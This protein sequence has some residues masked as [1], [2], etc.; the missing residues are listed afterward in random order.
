MFRIGP[1][2]LDVRRRQLLFAANDVHLTPKAFDLLALLADAAPRVVTKTELHRNLWPHRIVSDA[3]LVGLVK[4]LRRAFAAHEPRVN[5]IRTAHRV[6]YAIDLPVLCDGSFASPSRWLVTAAE[7]LPLVSGE[8][9]IGRDT[10][11]NVRLVH[12]MVSRR[13]ARIVVGPSN[14]MLEDLG[15]KN[16]TLL[17]GKRVIEPVALQDGSRITFG[18]V[19]ATYRETAAAMSTLA[20]AHS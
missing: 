6:G 11:A 9:V 15:S 20:E 8:N 13:H 10:Q 7:S 19:L 4:E 1:F 3:T 12:A 14:A 5:P 2:E 18:H 17:E 16:G